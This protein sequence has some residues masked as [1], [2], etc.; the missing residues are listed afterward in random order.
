MWNI[1][2]FVA[3][4]IE[5]AVLQSV[6]RLQLHGAKWAILNS[7]NWIMFLK[8]MFEELCIFG[9][10]STG[11]QMTQRYLAHTVML[12]WK[13]ICSRSMR[14]S[15]NCNPVLFLA[16]VSIWTWYTV[17]TPQVRG[18]G[19][20]GSFCPRY[21]YILTLFRV[22]NLYCKIN[23]GDKFVL[24]LIPSRW[25][26]EEELIN[27]NVILWLLLLMRRRVKSQNFKVMEQATGK[28]GK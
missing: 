9:C 3:L 19:W 1:F 14:W 17:Q 23:L 6:C 11:K 13:C 28:W 2:C 21:I 26:L 20:E 18:E 4:C 7:L 15:W 27:I 8:L 5:A 22:T 24:Y 25:S 12:N 16:Y 10:A